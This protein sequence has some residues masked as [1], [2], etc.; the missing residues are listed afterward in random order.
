MMK[1]EAI[2]QIEELYKI[3]KD[4]LIAQQK[5]K[6]YSEG[7]QR[8]LTG[9]YPDN[10]H[11]IFEL[12]QNA[13]D[14]GASKVSFELSDESLV[15]THNGDKLFDYNDVD[16]ITNIGFSTKADDINSIGKFGV[17][18][19]AV[20]AYT[21]T[22]RIFSGEYCFEIHDLICPYPLVEFNNTGETRFEFPFNHATKSQDDAFLEISKG[23]K[24]L[25]DNVL[26]FL[27]N[28]KQITI[29]IE[30]AGE[31][32]ISSHVH[33]NN[34]IEIRHQRIGDPNYASSYWL[35]FISPIAEGNNLYVAIALGLGFK[36]KERTIFDDSVSI[37]QQMEIIPV[38]GQLSIFF[39]ADKEATKLKFHIH[40]PYASTVAR[41]SIP[42]EN[43]DNK[44]LIEKTAVLLS[45][46]L[47]SVKEMGLLTISFLE[48]LP[49]NKDGLN[50]FYRLLLD[51]VIETMKWFPL[52]PTY[53]GDHAPASYLLQGPKDI[54]EVIT[55]TEL[56]F[57]TKKEKIKWVTGV[58]QN[59][60]ADDFIKSIE[61]SD[62][63]WKE[64]VEAVKYRFNRYSSNFDS[65]IEWL[66]N[67][68]EEWMQRFYALLENAINNYENENRYAYL[69]VAN[70]IVIRTSLGEH[71]AGNNVYFPSN[72]NEA[73]LDGL[74]RVKPEILQGRNKTRIEKARRFLERAGVKEAGEREEILQILKSYYETDTNLPSDKLHLQHIKKFV[75]YWKK[76]KDKEVFEDFYIIKDKTGENYCR[77][78]YL[79]IDQPYLDTGLSALFSDNSEEQEKDALWHG[80]L[81]LKNKEFVNFVIDL[82]VCNKVEIQKSSTYYH[83]DRQ[84]LHQYSNARNTEYRIDEDYK[85]EKLEEYFQKK[86]H[87]LNLL[88]W[89][90]ISKESP[91]VLRAQFRPN[92]QYPI[93]EKPSTLVYQLKSIAWIPDKSGDLYKPEDISKENLHPDF[94]PDDRNGWLTAI[95]FGDNIIKHEESYKKKKEMAQHLGIP[96]DLVELF[97]NVSEEK[98]EQV[99]NQ[100][101]ELV[102][103]AKS[104]N[105]AE[106]PPSSPSSDP[107]RRAKIAKEVAIKAENI[108]YEERNRSVRT[109][110]DSPQAKEYLR[111]HNKNENGNV[112]CQLCNS[113]MPFKLNGGYDY[114]EAVQFISAI[115]KEIP[116]NHIALCPNCAAEFKHACNTNDDEKKSL[117]LSL[118]S[119]IPEGHLK[120]MLDMPVHKQLRFTQN[121]LIDL[122][123]TLQGIRS[124]RENYQEGELSN[125]QD[126]QEVIHNVSNIDIIPTI[127]MQAKPQINNKS[128]VNSEESS[129]KKYQQCPYCNMPVKASKYHKHINFICP[130]NRKIKRETNIIVECPFCKHKMVTSELDNHNSI[131]H[132]QRLKESQQ[133][134][135]LTSERTQ[136]INTKPSEAY[137]PNP[138]MKS[139]TYCRGSF[140]ERRIEEHIENCYVRHR[141]EKH[142]RLIPSITSGYVVNRPKC[143]FCGRHAMFGS[144]VCNSCSSD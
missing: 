67:Q 105:N 125:V 11:F 124:N 99:L 65:N 93:M 2:K 96:F 54:K 135:K 121:H 7:L 10:A 33:N 122:H 46:S 84:Y 113:K 64:L 66:R 117:V 79:Y 36:D 92:Q 107:D 9:L 75:T 59:S 37:N 144:D 106:P 111:N 91:N 22:P 112:I 51:K 120:I 13:E 31:S 90:T 30:G 109:S 48:T 83:Q 15:F 27:N 1:E 89:K 129:K 61:I 41:D 95:G 70:W 17:G 62:W 119:T 133:I 78:A 29:E 72:E 123:G 21:R 88:I 141:E 6:G 136:P 101:K 97:N 56:P 44:K 110:N 81:D 100:F 53:E 26:L 104:S 20:F 34:L 85:I 80:Y 55:D 16:S 68:S 114:F 24:D 131:C 143:R 4:I 103:K 47:F 134:G 74:T 50:E 140:E 14:A 98:K 115:E 45:K 19:K 76:E 3:G 40:A 39:P 132:I 69:D 25:K 108:K 8:I 102:E 12:L 38:E 127:T 137:K 73:S 116:E 138:S 42:P 130:Q 71:V 52:V 43:N 57:F 28:I 35:R 86:D 5:K 126:K 49:N 60:R 58:M 18:F 23:L 118:D 63:K 139:C 142:E 32:N 94:L 77:P 87:H 82:G 128:S